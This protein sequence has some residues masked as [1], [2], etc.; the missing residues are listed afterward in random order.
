MTKVYYL[1]SPYS[2]YPAGHEQAFID[3]CKQG[4][5]LAMNG[6]YT[7]GAIAHTHP[8]AMHGE[9]D[10]QDHDFWLK[11]D[12]ALIDKLDGMIVCMMEGW[13]KSVGVLR[14]IEYCQKTGKP[15]FYMTPGQVPNL[16]LVAA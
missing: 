13:D 10:N 12:F 14:E 15:I 16:M 4:A 7:M 1:A 5:F 6:I 11:W 8:I 3:I 2:K 9:I